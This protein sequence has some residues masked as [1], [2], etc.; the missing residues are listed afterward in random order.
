[1]PVIEFGNNPKR[2]KTG[3]LVS[4]NLRYKGAS[5]LLNSRYNKRIVG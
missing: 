4:F 5:G 2:Y 3:D 1:M